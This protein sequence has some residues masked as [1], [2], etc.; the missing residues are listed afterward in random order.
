MNTP[1]HI[2]SDTTVGAGCSRVVSAKHKATNIQRVAKVID[3]SQERRAGLELFYNETQTLRQLNSVS[4]DHVVELV[5]SC[6]VGKSAVLVLERMD[7]DLLDHIM[8]DSLTI[9]Q[10]LTIFYKI[11]QS[12]LFC[13]QQNIAHLDLKPDNILISK[14]TLIVKLAD[15]GTSQTI[16][17]EGKVFN[18][19]GTLFYNSPEVMQQGS[20]GVD[21][22]SAEVWSLGILLHVLLT[23]TWPLSSDDPVQVRA[24][25]SNGRL[26]FAD[27]LSKDQTRFL[28][29][30]LQFNPR[31]RLTLAEIL[32]SDFLAP[33]APK[34]S[35]R[36]RTSLGPHRRLLRWIS[37]SRLSS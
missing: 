27:C 25:V 3:I 26:F 33:Y 18:V 1:D 13:H 10:R 21:A 28:T 5:E 23:G 37:S 34:R 4:K 20:S 2:L 11:C 17:K 9:E 7:G 29:Q 30:L 16:T 36:R 22:E 8:D 14:D 35:T 19:Q 15:F 12:V 6:V 31:S 32:Q 24:H